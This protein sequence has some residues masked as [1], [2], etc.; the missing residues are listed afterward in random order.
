MLTQQSYNLQEAAQNE[1]GVDVA[2]AIVDLQNQDYLL[3]VSQKLGAALLP[4]TLL[5]YL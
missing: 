4:K 2:R 3:Q 1:N 5:D